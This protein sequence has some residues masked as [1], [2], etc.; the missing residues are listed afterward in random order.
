M[1]GSAKKAAAHETKKAAAG[2]CAKSESKTPATGESPTSYLL[3]VPAPGVRASDVQ[4]SLDHAYV[5]RITGKSPTSG[6]SVATV[7]TALRLPGD[8]N[9]ATIKVSV[10]EGLVSI[11]VDKKQPRNLRVASR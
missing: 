4:C 8:A 2:S 5:V 3:Q 10:A 1:T 9:E 6:G 11:T 7:D